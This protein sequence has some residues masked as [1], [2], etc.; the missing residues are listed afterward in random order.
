MQNIHT[1][2]LIPPINEVQTLDAPEMSRV[3]RNEC[4]TVDHRN[5]RNVNVVILNV[6]SLAELNI[7]IDSFVDCRQVVAVKVK[8]LG[9]IVKLIKIFEHTCFAR[10]L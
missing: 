6:L 4:A 1:L 5:C 10:R 8:M 3:R 2:I 7:N 9:V